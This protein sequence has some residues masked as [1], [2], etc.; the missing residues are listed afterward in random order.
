MTSQFPH[1]DRAQTEYDLYSRQ[2]NDVLYGMCRDWPTHEDRGQVWAKV[3]I[4]GRSYAS[5]LERHANDGL[6]MVVDR[7]FRNRRSLDRLTSELRELDA[8][9]TFPSIAKAARVHGYLLN[10]L[11]PHMREGNRPRSF[12]AKYL[13]FHA[14]C[15]PIY[16]SVVSGRISSRK[17][18]PWKR[19]WTSDFP[20]PPAA[21]KEYW[22]YCVRLAHMADDWRA[23]GMMPDA[24]MLDYY[25]LTFRD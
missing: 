14:P 19:Q 12:V 9:V 24:R 7:L 10:K 21:D 2:L 15:I 6:G 11:L 16:D 22:A 17:W 25:L 8:E 3:W 13:H 18:Y 4:I 23:E 20:P 5:G 1:F